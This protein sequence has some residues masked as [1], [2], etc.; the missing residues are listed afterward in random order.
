MRWKRSTVNVKRKAD[1]EARLAL[2]KEE[3][4]R[5][6]ALIANGAHPDYQNGHPKDA[7]KGRVIITKS[8]KRSA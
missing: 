6:L 2:A 8:S 7:E 1:A 3:K 5:R 4:E